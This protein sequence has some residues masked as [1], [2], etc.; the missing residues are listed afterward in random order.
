MSAPVLP[1]RVLKEGDMTRTYFQFTC[2][3]EGNCGGGCE[4]VL[5][6]PRDRLFRMSSVVGYGKKQFYTTFECPVCFTFTDVQYQDNIQNNYKKMKESAQHAIEVMK[7]GERGPGYD[8]TCTGNGFATGCCA[9]LRVPKEHFFK[10][11]DRTAF[12]CPLCD[13]WSMVTIPF[14]A[15]QSYETYKKYKELLS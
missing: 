11:N 2:T 9:I 14:D 13:K 1:I 10:M 15:R 12:E 3:G 4:S 6:V 5:K 7:L 8:V